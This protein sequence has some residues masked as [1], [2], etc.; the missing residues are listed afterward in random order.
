MP[1]TKSKSWSYQQITENTR[2][3]IAKLM[4]QANTAS[5]PFE[6]TLFRQWAWGAYM[7]WDSITNGHQ[8]VRDACELMQLANP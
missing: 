4:A 7:T 2:Q 8:N 6:Q 1:R 3:Q 5:L